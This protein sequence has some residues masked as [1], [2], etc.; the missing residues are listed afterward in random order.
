MKQEEV[1]QMFEKP[2]EKEKVSP[3]K[4]VTIRD[5]RSFMFKSPGRD[6]LNEKKQRELLEMPGFEKYSPNKQFVLKQFGAVKIGSGKKNTSLVKMSPCL[7]SLHPDYIPDH[8]LR[9]T[10]NRILNTM[11]NINKIE[12]NFNLDQYSLK[13]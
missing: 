2:L 10:R 3:K 9:F 6:V 4:K 11:E 7:G 5:Q 12:S 1:S 8:Q 13:G